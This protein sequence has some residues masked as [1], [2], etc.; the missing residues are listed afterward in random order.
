MNNTAE[1]NRLIAEFLG[2]DKAVLDGYDNETLIRHVKYHFDWNW[3]M[4]VIDKIETLEY[5]D[6]GK[7]RFCSY[8][9]MFHFSAEKLD[10]SKSIPELNYYA[11][12]EN[13]IRGAH[14]AV[15][16]FIKWYNSSSD[17]A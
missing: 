6:K 7:Y 12:V 2:T 1:N 13:K 11:S 15:V 4:G 17:K 14:K 3:L 8:G 5:K 16:E 10:N 9:Y